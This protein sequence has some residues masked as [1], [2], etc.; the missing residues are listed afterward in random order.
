AFSALHHLG[1]SE[2]G[3]R[4]C[5]PAM[6]ALS[7]VLFHR[8]TLAVIG[9]R[10]H[11]T[12]RPATRLLAVLLFGLSPLAIGVGDAI[13][14][15]PLFTLLFSL[16]FILYLMAGNAA[17]RLGSAVALGLA[18]STN[19]LAAIVIAPLLL[20]RYALQRQF[21]PRFEIAYWLVFS[22]FG[23]LGFIW[24]FSLA[25]K[26]IGPIAGQQF[27]NSLFRAVASH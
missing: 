3:M 23:R 6:T 21:R 2:A 17:A 19:F 11:A 13:R 7:L 9:E 4:L 1:L 12:A 24:A 15:Y 10:T 18:A 5:S 25:F 14:W 8:L 20:Y 27:E 26:Q 22:L 16:F